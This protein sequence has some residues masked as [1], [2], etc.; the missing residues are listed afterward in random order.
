VVILDL[1]NQQEC[2]GT[3]AKALESKLQDTCS[4]CNVS[5]VI[6][7]RKF[8]NWLIAAPSSLEEQP[9]R[10][11]EAR[12]VRAAS[13][14][15]KSDHVVDAEELLKRATARRDYDKRRDSLRIMERADV[16]ELARNSRS[17]RRFLCVLG[18]PV[19]KSGS[20]VYSTANLRS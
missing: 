4:P 5:V 7:V 13:C 11:P 6:K 18:C 8:E 14:P 15:N 19:Y 3:R 17:F 20:K 2:A 12:I 10:F 1:E 9:Q 16:D